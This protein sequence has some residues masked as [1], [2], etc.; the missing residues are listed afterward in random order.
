MLN[1]NIK[2]AYH[3]GLKK[4][5]FRL[6]DAIEEE[7]DAALGN[8]GLGRLA[9][10]FMDSLAT[11]DYPA[12]GYG[13]RYTY[14][15][16]KQHIVDG[17]QTEFPDYWLTF[18]NPWEIPRVDVFYDIKFKGHVT[19]TIDGNGNTKYSTEGAERVMAVAYDY[20][21]PG[22]GTKNTIN[23]RLWS[24]K[25]NREF[26]LASFNEGNYDKSVEEQKSAENITSVLYPNDNHSVG[27]ALRLKQ[28]YF[29]VSATLQDILRRFKKSCR[30]WS[31]F[32]E[33][34]AIQLN[35]THPTLG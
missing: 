21:I 16:F 26:D 1:M 17:Y 2:G 33:Q 25:P 29:F 3:E 32:P 11:L 34:V 18:G 19:K 27:K 28:Q 10:C 35:D 23:I 30:P 15:I 7:T 12:W 14:G 5:G 13:I 8:G 4:L 20:P 22:F 6:E 9:A 24:S 31:E